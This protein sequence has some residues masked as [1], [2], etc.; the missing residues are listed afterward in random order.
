MEKYSDMASSGRAT[1]LK[2]VGKHKVRNN[3][4]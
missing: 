1:A 4:V 2:L 3:P